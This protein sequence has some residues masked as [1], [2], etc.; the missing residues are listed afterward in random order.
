MKALFVSLCLLLQA[1]PLLADTGDRFEAIKAFSEE[2]FN[3]GMNVPEGYVAEYDRYS[4]LYLP[5]ADYDRLHNGR[6]WKGTCAYWQA[7]VEKDNNSKILYPWLPAHVGGNASH[8]KVLF[9]DVFRYTDNNY[10]T[11]LHLAAFLGFGHD[12]EKPKVEPSWAERI[13]KFGGKE[14]ASW[15]NADS[16]YVVDFPITTTFETRYTH[17]IGIYMAKKG[18]VP[19]FLKLL[20]TDESYAQRERRL[21]GIRGSIVFMKD[22]WNYD[23]QKMKS[24]QEDLL[25][26]IGRW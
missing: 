22:A 7:A 16:V 11:D 12:E 20:L 17:C 6:N 10:L 9:H 8:D 1:S 19:V 13:T 24:A 18:Y 23:R 5:N 14:A 26:R 15:G 21:R 3:I 2:C 25:K 4:T